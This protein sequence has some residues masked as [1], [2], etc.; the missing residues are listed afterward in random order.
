MSEKFKMKRCMANRSRIIH[1]VD[2]DGFFTNDNP[3]RR[4]LGRLEA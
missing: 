2:Q 4:R 1:R 3:V